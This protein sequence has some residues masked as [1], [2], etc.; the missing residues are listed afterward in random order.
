MKSKLLKE[1]DKQDKE[2]LLRLLKGLSR[3]FP[4]AKM[5][6]NMEFGIDTLPIIEKY[7]KLIDKEYFPSRGNGKA[8]SSKVNRTIKEFSRLVVFPEDLAD[9]RLH[10]VE[11]AVRFMEAHHYQSDVF[12]SNLQTQWGE[13][14]QYLHKHD[15]ASSFSDRIENLLRGTWRSKKMQKTFN[16]I[17]IEAENQKFEMVTDDEPD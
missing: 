16:D 4:L 2:E 17:W 14:A 6:L 12:L 3:R 9:I 1:L 10:Q 11:Q 5:Y 8:R 13:T 15:L 7:K